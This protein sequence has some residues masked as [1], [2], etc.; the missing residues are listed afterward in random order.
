MIIRVQTKMRESTSSA[1]RLSW[2][3]PR[4]RA[5]EAFFTLAFCRVCSSV[6]SPRMYLIPFSS[7]SMSRLWIFSSFTLFTMTMS[8]AVRPGDFRRIS[9][10]RARISFFQPK[11]MT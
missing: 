8:S 2:A 11:M 6:K 7:L 5:V 1:S 10:I 4:T 3:S 9:P